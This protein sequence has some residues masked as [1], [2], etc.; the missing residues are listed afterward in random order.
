MIL[1][2]DDVRD[3]A[4][5][6]INDKSV[7]LI[8]APPYD[9]DITGTLHPGA[10]K[11]EIAVTNEWTNRIIGDRSLPENQRILP[12]VPPIRFGPPP[13]LPDSGI[14]GN[15]T[16]LSESSRQGDRR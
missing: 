3:I 7:G 6:K 13:A 1:H 8:W 5:I 14:S 9:V 15:I 10:N 12:G 16:L 4:Q 2:L 11:L